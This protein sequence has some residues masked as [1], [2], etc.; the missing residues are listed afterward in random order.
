MSTSKIARPS[1]S[2]QQDQK[3]VSFERKYY[4][5]GISLLCC[6]SIYYYAISV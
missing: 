4:F 2:G 6:F 5:L 3:K 1:A